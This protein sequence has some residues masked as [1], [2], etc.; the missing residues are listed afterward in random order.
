MSNILTE[1]VAHK[2][3]ELVGKKAEQPI[4]DLR[5][6]ATGLPPPVVFSEALRS[7]PMGLIAEAKRRSPSAGAIRDPFDAADIVGTYQRAGAQA[8][9]VLMDEK[10]FG[11]GTADFR[12]ARAASELP[13]LYKEFVIDPW[14]VWHARSLGASVVLLIAGVLDVHELA[15]MQAECRLAGLE[16]LVEVHDKDQMAMAVSAGASCIGINNRDLTTFTVSLETTFRLMEHT[17]DGCTVISESGIRC[18]EDVLS[19]KRHGAHAVLVGEHL[20]RQPDLGIA[21][22][23]LMAEVWAS[24]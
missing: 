17:P 4:D 6:E 14:Q 13:I 16:S 5:E 3:N 22:H 12:A 19:L 1:I 10:Y 23:E 18:A 21:V 15:I 7:S 24:L 2:R 20:L 8:C 11:G 9:S